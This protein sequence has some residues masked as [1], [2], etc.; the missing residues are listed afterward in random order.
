M[1]ILGGIMRSDIKLVAIDLDGTLLDYHKEVSK[2]NIDAIR[3]LRD[4][5]IYIVIATG[6][7]V[8]GFS[9]I[10]DEIS[11]KGRDDYSITNTGSLII[12]NKDKTNLWKKSLTMKDFK[13]VKKFINDKMQIGI[14]NKN[15]ILNN[16]DVVNKDFLF[17]ADILRMPIEKF[18][19]NNL[20]MEVDRI[21]ITANRQVM[22]EFSQKYNHILL[23]DYQTVRNVFEVFEVLNKEANKGKALLA[24]GEKLKI[25]TSQMLA[26]GDSNNDKSMLSIVEIP[27]ACS[28]A[29]KSVKDMCKLVSDFSNDESGVAD[30]LGKVFDI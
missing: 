5:G 18:D 1:N 9:W 7:P 22:D 26:I 8:A 28:N 3:K 19:E 29:R 2:K 15:K 24:L 20:S 27:A 4:K 17:E 23:K 21:T 16:Y 6:R 14:Y 30:I 11:L 10:L 13:K 25:K 12:K